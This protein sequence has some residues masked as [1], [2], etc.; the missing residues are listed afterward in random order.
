MEEGNTLR[1]V[2]VS[3][4]NTINGAQ[5]NYS[6]TIINENAMPSGSDIEIH[7]PAQVEFS[8]S[9]VCEVAGT[10]VT[11]VTCSYSAGKVTAEVTFAGDAEAAGG[12]TI[13]FV[14]KDCKN[15]PSTA[16]SDTFQVFTFTS[17]GYK[18][19]KLETGITVQTNTAATITDITIIGD[20]AKI[21][22]ETAYIIRYTPINPHPEGT[23][24]EI[25]VPS[26]FTLG[27]IA[28]TSELTLDA[29]LTCT[30]IDKKIMVS[31]GFTATNSP[32]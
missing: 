29:A 4:D 7:P 24:L 13:E 19:D 32:V 27:T 23:E 31:G 18:I 16:P 1:S 10:L 11:A 8:L 28:C 15:P 30:K 26:G 3:T 2:S 20:T 12:S 21:A 5:G 6:F 22:E 25:D 17:A 9:P 14:V